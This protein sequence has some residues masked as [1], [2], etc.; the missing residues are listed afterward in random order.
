MIKY[1]SIIVKNKKS[2]TGLSVIQSK[3]KAAHKKKKGQ[4]ICLSS[5][6][7]IVFQLKN[8]KKGQTD[9]VTLHT[10]QSL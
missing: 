2:Q 9:P 5:G 7:I 8:I 10:K 6:Y 1:L 4:T 3:G